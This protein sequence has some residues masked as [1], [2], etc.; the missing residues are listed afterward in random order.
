MSRKLDTEG[1]FGIG[2]T[3]WATHGKPDTTN[4]HPHFNQSETIAVVHNG[5]IENYEVLKTQLTENGYKFISETDTEVI[6]HL[7]DYH[8]K[9]DLTDAVTK[10]SAELEGSYA[11]CVICKDEPDKIVALKKGSPLIIAPNREGVFIASD[12]TAVLHHTD[13]VYYMDDDEIALV[14]KDEITFFNT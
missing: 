9:G 12:T 1:F 4:S 7:I 13:K 14:T 6:P 3:R 11:I 8:Y 10:A 2:H 5:I